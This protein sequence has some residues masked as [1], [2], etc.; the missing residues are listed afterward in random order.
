MPLVAQR[1]LLLSPLKR[2]LAR[3]STTTAAQSSAAELGLC[4]LR[5]L[6]SSAKLERKA[7]HGGAWEASPAEAPLSSSSAAST[8]SRRPFP[9]D[10][11]E[12]D[13]DNFGFRS[14]QGSKSGSRIS[15]RDKSCSK[16]RG[17]IGRNSKPK[18]LQRRFH[19]DL[20]GQ[21]L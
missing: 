4:G 16:R 5:G 18:L 12:G 21:S 8:T 19:K 17:E 7:S 11:C 1:M 14:P 2:S 15:C 13:G 3:S 9:Q 6:G 10:H 20:G